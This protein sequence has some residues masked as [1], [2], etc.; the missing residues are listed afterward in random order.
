MYLQGGIG[1]AVLCVGLLVCGV[2][3]GRIPVGGGQ[4]GPS[5]QQPSM[6]A[7][8]N[9]RAAGGAPAQSPRPSRPLAIVPQQQGQQQG[10]QQQQGLTTGDRSASREVEEPLL[11][12]ISAISGR[13]EV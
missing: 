5:R 13:P 3:L 4:G 2:V 9:A 7:N 1:T 6:N 11:G 8:T 12:G 10:Q